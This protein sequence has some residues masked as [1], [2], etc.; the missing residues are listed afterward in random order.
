MYHSMCRSHWKISRVSIGST[1]ILF[2]SPEQVSISPKIMY[3][4]IMP[5][6]FIWIMENERD[7]LL[8]LPKVIL[9]YFFLVL[10]SP[11]ILYKS[12]GLLFWSV[13]NGTHIIILVLFI[14]FFQI[15]CRP[16]YP[17]ISLNLLIVFYVTCYMSSMHFL[18]SDSKLNAPS[19]ATHD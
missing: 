6:Y 17:F 14:Y 11:T 12:V 19:P 7:F 8:M 18:N 16:N 15:M 5:C 4:H 2:P 1:V 13:N 9:L 3:M 10:F